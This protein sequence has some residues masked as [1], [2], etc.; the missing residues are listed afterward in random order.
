MASSVTAASDQP[1]QRRKFP[2]WAR[3]VTWIVRLAL[4]YLLYRVVRNPWPLLHS[5]VFPALLLWIGF[6][7]YW[8]RAARNRA[9]DRSSETK[10]STLFHQIVL[11]AALLLLF[12]PVPGLTAWFLPERLHYLV[13]VGAIIQAAFIFLAIW[14]RRHL[15]RNWSGSVRIGE[16]HELVRSGPYRLMRHPI[17]TAMLGMSLGTAISS[18]QYHALLGLVILFL[19]Y[20]RK[21]RLE[22]QI[23]QQTF[24]AEYD[25]YRCDT[26]A[27]VPLVF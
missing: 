6:S 26:W 10:K 15:G 4:L 14:A 23:L 13:P 21:T 2:L 19:A 8:G 22:E 5:R 12:I 1:L 9:P 20:L 7:V 3:I 16:G 18:S 17:Y 27:L 24:G 11:N 25:A